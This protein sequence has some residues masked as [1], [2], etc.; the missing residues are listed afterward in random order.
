MLK[1]IILSDLHIVPEG[2]LS[3]GLDTLDRLNLAI[4]HVNARHDDAAFVICAGDLADH[5]EAAA[6][7]RLKTALERL[8][9]PT[10]LTLGNHDHRPTFLE[11]FG[12]DLAGPTGQLDRV[13]DAE[14][15]RIVILDSS[16]PDLAGSGRLAATQLD[17]LGA[18][19][20]EAADRPVV[21][22]L[23]HNITRFHIQTD[24][25]IL[26]DADAFVDVL[27]GHPDIRQVISGHVH[28]TAAGS[29]RGV[30]FCTLGGAHYSIE[31]VLESR[32]G[33][34]PGGPVPRREGPGELAVVLCDDRS[35]VVHMERFLDRH[36][37]LAPDL[38][39]WSPREA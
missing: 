26:E 34:V 11:V 13:I 4:D 24:F 17:W 1:F 39:A 6:Y 20:R 18:Q 30:P 28:L 37:L 9:L 31:P 19:L 25:I 7:E 35:T 8:A 10:Y 32:S 23:H 22:V 14:G 27:R 3:H 21:V 38:F 12:Q 5:G 15:H 36:L 2:R 33:P 29:V 16:D